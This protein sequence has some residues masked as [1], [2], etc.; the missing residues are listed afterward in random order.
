MRIRLLLL[1]AL[2]AAL[3]AGQTGPSMD[4]PARKLSVLVGKWKTEGAF[5]S[6]QKTRTSLECR[7]SP[8]GYFLVCDQLVNLGGTDHRQFTVYS[9]DGKEKRYSYTTL[10]DP[11]AKPT[12]GP[13]DIKG[14]LWT[15]NSSFEAQGKTTLI[16]TTND[17]VDPRTELFKVTTSTDGGDH[18]TTMLEGKAQKV[19]D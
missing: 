4:D 19:A 18:W 3:C 8:S 13:I 1:F 6:G 5:S 7:W 10:A 15:Y 11:G 9:Y 12:S 16:R 14:N 17:F 2:V